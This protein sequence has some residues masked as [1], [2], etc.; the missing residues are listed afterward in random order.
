MELKDVIHYYIGCRC[1]NTWFP[2]GHKELNKGWVLSGYCQLYADGGKPFLLESENEVTWTDSIKPILF[3]LEDMTEQQMIGLLQSMVPANMDDKPK[4]EDYD[5]E[6][7]YNDDGLM[8]DGDVSVGANYTCRCYE[9]QIGIK[10]C[11]SIILFEEGKDVT[12]NELTNTPMAFHYLL[13]Q[14]FDLFGLIDAG[15]AIDS[16]TLKSTV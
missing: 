15:I 13:T 9:G 4:D 16:K 6:M 7:F 1:F 2:E 5:L 10:K 14:H 3:R 12:R 11:G 8:V